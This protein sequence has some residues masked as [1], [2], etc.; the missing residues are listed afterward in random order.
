MK[1]TESSIK[2]IVKVL[3]NATPVFTVTIYNVRFENENG[4][5]RIQF[6]DSN[7]YT[8]SIYIYGNDS[9]HI[10]FGVFDEKGFYRWFADGDVTK[11]TIY[12]V[13]FMIASKIKEMCDYV[14]NVVIPHDWNEYHAEE[15]VEPETVETVEPE[16]VETVEPETTTEPDN[17]QH[18]KN[19]GGIAMKYIAHTIDVN[20][21]GEYI[22]IE[23]TA[24]NDEDAMCEINRIAL[25]SGYTVEFVECVPEKPV[26][27]PDSTT[28]EPETTTTEP[29][30]ER[31]MK[32]IE[33]HYNRL[34]WKHKHKVMYFFESTFEYLAAIINYRYEQGRLSDIQR[35][36]LHIYLQEKRFELETMGL[37]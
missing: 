21:S 22:D 5:Y 34:L 30:I 3:E 18:I 7:N 2:K 10:Q 31:V 20:A 8:H 9:A 12:D 32:Q 14:D 19:E 16:T 37:A 11:C 1:I 13:V 25:E 23:V 28:T 15:T 24:N 35:E 27:E 36:F 6:E 4:E 26:T 29:E 17:A 33:T